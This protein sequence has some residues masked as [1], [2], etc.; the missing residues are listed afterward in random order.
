[1]IRLIRSLGLTRPCLLT[2]LI[3]GLAPAAA[4]AQ[5][6]RFRNETTGPVIVKT[7]Y[8]IRG[9]VQQ[10]PT[11]VLNPMDMTPA[12][13]LPGSKIITI[14]DGPRNPNRVLFQGTIPPSTD[15]LG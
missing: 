1:M 12:I 11:F 9:V 8:I 10:G 3:V 6:L 14:C 2:L 4:S 13:L 7:A 15:D 5:S